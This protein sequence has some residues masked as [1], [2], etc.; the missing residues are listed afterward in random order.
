MRHVVL[1]VLALA[2][3][4]WLAPFAHLLSKDGRYAEIAGIVAIFAVIDFAIGRAKAAR[5]P[6]P[7]SA[8]PSATPAQRGR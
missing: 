4:W 2:T 1:F 7:R 8:T 3:A 5:K 6:A